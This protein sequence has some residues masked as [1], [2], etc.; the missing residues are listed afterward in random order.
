MQSLGEKIRFMIKNKGLSQAKFAKKVGISQSLLSQQ[1]NGE[2][3]VT[4][5]VLDLYV[6]FFYNLDKDDEQLESKIKEFLLGTN[7]YT[8]PYYQGIS[9]YF[10]VIKRSSSFFAKEKLNDKNPKKE[11]SENTVKKFSDSGLKGFFLGTAVASIAGL[12]VN[13]MTNKFANKKDKS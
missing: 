2:K 4:Y 8:E 6:R 11:S 3:K 10:A 5:E 12:A 13:V 1:I 7:E 9:N